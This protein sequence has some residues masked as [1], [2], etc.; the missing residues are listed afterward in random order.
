MDAARRAG[1]RQASIATA[2]S[3]FLAGEIAL[4]L[5]IVPCGALVLATVVGPLVMQCTY[6]LCVIARRW[7]LIDQRQ[8]CPECLRLLDHPARI[9]QLS[10]TSL[11]S[12]GTEFVCPKGH[13][14]LY[15]PETSTTS[16]P[17]TQ[18]WMHLGRSWSGLF[19]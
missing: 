8:R 19:S 10:H 2:P 13:G 1:A 5:P 16:F 3:M 18:R 7:A 11:D 14:L 6:V 4:V 17:R 9:G 12:C 15:V